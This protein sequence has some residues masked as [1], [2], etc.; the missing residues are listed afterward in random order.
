MLKRLSALIRKVPGWL[1]LLGFSGLVFAAIEALPALPVEGAGYLLGL[2]AAFLA[3]LGIFTE[4]LREDLA[5]TDPAAVVATAEQGEDSRTPLWITLPVVGLLAVTAIVCLWAIGAVAA[6]LGDG[7]RTAVEIALPLGGYLLAGLAGPLG[8]TPLL[9]LIGLFRS[10]RTLGAQ[11]D[12][13]FDAPA[14][15]VS[16]L[17]DLSALPDFVTGCTAPTP[18]PGSDPPAFTLRP[19]TLTAWLA[20]SGMTITI[21][22]RAAGRSIA[23][24]TLTDA[25][26]REQSDLRAV[27]CESGAA[28]RLRCRYLGSV[29]SAYVLGFAWLLGDRH[30]AEGGAHTWA[31]RVRKATRTD[32]RLDRMEITLP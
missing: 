27:P 23:F 29:R 14:D 32:A 21:T 16:A 20:R 7:T 12:L 6:R 11:F 31:M 2:C 30:I 17:A 24:E 22:H 3:S 18:V 1:R 10:P 25:G 8:L 28:L 5:G 13:V 4:A 19:T 9:L 15:P 26:D